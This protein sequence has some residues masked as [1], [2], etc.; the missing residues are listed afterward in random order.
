MANYDRRFLV[1]YLQDLCSLELM[2]AKIQRNIMSTE[3]KVN[4]LTNICN[5]KVYDPT[6]PR[7]EQFYDD[8]NSGKSL[9]GAGCIIELVGN[10]IV[11]LLANTTLGM[12]FYPIIFILRW[13]VIIFGILSIL[14]GLSYLHD[15]NSNAKYKYAKSV[16]EY[17][18]VRKRNAEFRNSL[19]A[20]RRELDKANEELGNL[21]T[22]YAS[23]KKLRNQA[24]GINVVPRQYRNIY[25]VYYLYDFFSTSKETNLEN[26]IQ[27][28]VLEE[29]KQK[30]DKIIQQNEQIILNQR[31]QIALQENQNRTIANNHRLEMQKLAKMEC[32]QEL[33]LDYQKMIETNQEVT[34]FILATDFSMKYR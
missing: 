27:T 24:Y 12:I 13:G 19:P 23:A 8:N 18:A 16:S 3:N 11:S 31:V 1:P 15:D 10:I 20:R 25:A 28:F 34:N 5:K 32:N 29:I 26:V 17:E 21:R 22:N 33:Q 14:F 6:T 30:L 9:I 7:L 2:C 4:E